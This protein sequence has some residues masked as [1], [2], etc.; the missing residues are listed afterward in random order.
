MSQDA[1]NLTVL[2]LEK[3]AAWPAWSAELRERAPNALV[4]AQ[5]DD[6]TIDAFEARVLG[7]LERLRQDRVEGAGY[8]CAPGGPD[9]QRV[10]QRLCHALIGLL[11]ANQDAQL[12]LGGGDWRDDDDTAGDRA[13]LLELWTALSEESPGHPVAVRFE[14]RVTTSGV[15]DSP[16]SQLLG[17][18]Q[19]SLG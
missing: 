2:L 10:R 19:R 7:R 12:I 17:L 4:E 14:D 18:G 16:G 9:H 1:Q 5:L 11:A 13:S 3:G 6:E 15:F 8:V